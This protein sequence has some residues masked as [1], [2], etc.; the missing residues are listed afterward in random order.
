MSAS[1]EPKHCRSCG[2]RIEWRKK[3]ERNWDEIAYCS[4]ACRSR[5]IRPVDRELE[6]W[7]LDR[8]GSAPRGRG[9]DPAHAVL[10]LD[11]RN[12]SDLREPAR[13][14]A[15]RLVNRGLAEMVQRGV[16]VDPSTAKGEV[17]LRAVR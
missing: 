3:W 1:P 12:A 11:P 16:V 6:Q 4:D 17:S 2:R 7:L 13:N 8:L 15:R 14:A 9:V 10:A 5:K